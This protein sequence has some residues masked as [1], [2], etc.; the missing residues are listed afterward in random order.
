[1]KN[2][3][4]DA[5]AKRL[6]LARG[7]MTQQEVAR[8]LGISQSSLA[9]YERGSAMPSALFLA[10]FCRVFGASPGWLLTGED[11][12]ASAHRFPAG[13]RK[14]RGHAEVLYMVT[15]PRYSLAQLARRGFSGRNREHAER[16]IALP[17]ELAPYPE[18]LWAVDAEDMDMAPAVRPRDMVVVDVGRPSLASLQGRMALVR[19]GDS[20]EARRPVLRQIFISGRFAY[21]QK[22]HGGDSM[23]EAVPASR[24]EAMIL[25]T[26][27]LVLKWD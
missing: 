10:E 26:V 14:P 24:L 6:R 2:E 23:T 9:G 4:R 22:T 3:Y 17:R 27:R 5:L 13:H 25:G 7:A 20:G 21:L 16:S 12:A 19:F 8:A 18:R 15:I 1:M 11:E